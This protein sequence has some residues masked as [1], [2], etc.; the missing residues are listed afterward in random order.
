MDGWTA[1]NSGREEAKMTSREEGIENPEA[2]AL[3]IGQWL[4]WMD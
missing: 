1:P 2:L 4:Y 3:A